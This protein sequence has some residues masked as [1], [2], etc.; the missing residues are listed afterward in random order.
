MI[1]WNDT[2]NTKNNATATSSISSKMK[3]VYYIA[4]TLL[5]LLISSTTF[6]STSSQSPSTS[7]P[8][9]SSSLSES[10]GRSKTSPSATTHNNIIATA[11]STKSTT[12]AAAAASSSDTS[13][14]N[15]RY[16][17]PSK[18]RRQQQQRQRDED[19]N[20][21]SN[22]RSR[23]SSSS[24]DF[25]TDKYDRRTSNRQMK[26]K[27]NPFYHDSNAVGVEIVTPPPTNL[28]SGLLQIPCSI[29]I[30]IF[31][32][33][34]NDYRRNYMVEGDDDNT[35]IPILLSSE[36]HHHYYDI[37]VGGSSSYWE[38]SFARD[39]DDIHYTS[40][41]SHSRYTYPTS[42]HTGTI[43]PSTTKTTQYR[44]LE[45]YDIMEENMLSSS[46]S[47]LSATSSS[48]S[49]SDPAT[50]QTGTGGS[51]GGSGGF[52][53]RHG[54]GYDEMFSTK[55][56]SAFI[57]TGAQC[58]V[59][60]LSTARRLKLVSLIDR[61]YEGTA[62]GVGTVNIIGRIPNCSLLL[63]GDMMGD[64]IYEDG[65]DSSSSSSGI[66]KLFGVDIVVLG[67]DHVF[68][69]TLPPQTNNKQH[70]S[71]SS[72]SSSS[73]TI[74]S[75]VDL[76]LGL[77]V[78]R[79]LR[80]NV[81]LR[82]NGLEVQAI[83]MSDR[84]SHSHRVVDYG[85]DNEDTGTSNTKEQQDC[86]WTDVTIPFL[87]HN[88]E[89][90][91]KNNDDDDEQQRIDSNKDN[92]NNNNNNKLSSI[93]NHSRT[94]PS[95]HNP[96]PN[97]DDDEEQHNEEDD[98]KNIL[99][100]IKTKTTSSTRLSL[101]RNSFRDTLDSLIE[102]QDK[103]KLL[104]QEKLEGRRKHHNHNTGSNNG[105]RGSSSRKKVLFGLVPDGEEEDK[106]EDD[107]EYNKSMATGTET[108]YLGER[109]RKLGNKGKK[110]K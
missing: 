38:S 103:R 12:K 13:S 37:D 98:L 74:N 42:S 71:S 63:G 60:S 64:D 75:G 61:R 93:K 3:F 43:S 66:V 32:N 84:D 28:G 9:Q 99:Q 50:T 77:D 85:Y 48:S 83:K 15:H 19:E 55:P 21:I 79:Q 102:Q 22:K 56:I 23:S 81:N 20:S 94:S 58:T 16:R 91:E 26:K 86:L 100:R 104:Q 49:L 70:T 110:M 29:E 62:S 87:K 36:D 78:L 54:Y 4:I 109:R 69:P 18:K 8:R 30:P 97:R 88:N 73:S 80:A 14:G 44:N 76:L 65:D 11:S 92:L 31:G 33:S 40:S 41:T 35:H 107:H 34:N 2:K 51:L 52:R 68:T 67:T 96:F 82:V 72:S 95:H 17:L 46:S 10:T 39:A 25:E 47:P 108:N 106:E 27:L 59:M 101:S 1:L 57:D 90:E 6:A 105:G 45:D 53:E 89:K 7:T 24:D 5:L